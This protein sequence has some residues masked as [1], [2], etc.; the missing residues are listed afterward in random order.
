MMEL[1]C[2]ICKTPLTGGLDTWGHVGLEMCFDC[3]LALSR[4][5]E[6]YEVDWYGLAPHHHDL[7][8]TGSVIGSTV[9]DPLPAEKNE[10]GEYIVEPGLFFLPDDET[11]GYMGLWRDTRPPKTQLAR[12]RWKDGN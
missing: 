1:Y 7:S 10:L 6:T 3:E 4:E 12:R 9:F 5:A 11:G 8:I 2:T